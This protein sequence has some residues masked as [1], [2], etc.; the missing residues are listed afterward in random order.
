MLRRF[1]WDLRFLFLVF[2]QV[3]FLD[4]IT[5]FNFIPFQLY[6][7]GIVI[8][9][10]K[11]LDIKMLFWAFLFGMAIDIFRDT[12]GLSALAALVITALRPYFLGRLGFF[13]DQ[14]N[15]I[16]SLSSFSKMHLYFYVF[17]LIFL[18]QLLV[19]FIEYFHVYN[20]WE[21]FY[22]VVLS[23]ILSGFLI[24]FLYLKVMNPSKRFR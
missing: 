12:A 19:I 24:L 2:L 14:N 6:L 18:H 15:A 7:L 16:F 13:L 20:V 11:F 21:M 10:V 4:Q 1:F 22:T 8:S 5:I 9:P 3:F 17:S 23:S